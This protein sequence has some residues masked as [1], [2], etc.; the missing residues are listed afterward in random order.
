MKKFAAFLACVATIVMLSI[1]SANARPAPDG[2]ADLVEK[3]SPAVVNISTTQ[4]VKSPLGNGELPS[5]P[6]GHPFEEFNEFFKRF[7]VPEGNLKTNSLGS[8]FVISEDGYIATNNHVIDAAEDITITFGNDTEYQA[9]I[10][11]RDDKTDL[12]VLKIKDTKGKKF[13]FV[14]FGNSDQIR[15]GDWILAIGNPFGLGGTVTAG[16]VSARAR[17]INSG[18]YDDYIQTDASINRGNSGGPMFNMTGEVVGINTAI[19]SPSGGSVGIGFAIPANLARPLIEQLKA[20]KKIERGWLG[21]KIQTVTKEIAESMGLPVDKGALVAEVIAGGPAEKAGIKTGDVI[22]KFG[23]HDVSAMRDLP[24]QVATRD[25]GAKVEL[26]LIREGKE[27]KMTVKLGELKDEKDE[28]EVVTE[29]K[30]DD[31]IARGSEPLLGMH[32]A[33]ITDEMRKNFK[34]EKD[35]KGLAVVKVP[36]ESE[37]ALRGVNVGDVIVQLNQQPVT[38]TKEA[39]KALEGAISEG[40]KSIL[41]LISRAGNNIFL[42]LPLVKDKN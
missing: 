17:D 20:G 28:D 6:P 34:I 30:G 2:F 16:I 27:K 1:S 9:E 40:R 36:G 41:L 4:T 23:D 38:S 19:F 37:A 35:V 7:A 29:K 22:T 12:A 8:G 32:V 14:T 39:K 13:T 26:T 5:F 18:P 25:I 24:R 11:G 21:V 42:A 15:V 33:P 10:V 31:D 3:L